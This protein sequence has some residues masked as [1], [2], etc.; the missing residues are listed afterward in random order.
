VKRR[1]LAPAD[2]LAAALVLAL[3]LL[4][5][6][7]LRAPADGTLRVVIDADGHRRVEAFLPDRMV[8][9]TGPL[10]TTRIAI[11]NGR[12]RIVESPCPGKLCIRMGSVGAPGESAVC[13]PNR[14][15]V[16]VE[17]RAGEGGVDAISR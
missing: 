15:A 2:L 11:E 3:F 8:E 6:W 1:L 14:V 12:A 9:A 5:P 17:G 10:G 7:K 16:T 4:L 13:L